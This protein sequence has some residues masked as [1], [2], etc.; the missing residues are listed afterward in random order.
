MRWARADLWEHECGETNV[1]V[2]ICGITNEDDA[3]FAA[4]MGADAVG[5]MFAPSKRQIAPTK[6]ADIAK[7]LPPEVLTVGVFRDELPDRVVDITLGAGLRAAQLSGH[8]SPAVTKTVRAKVPFVIQAFTPG[9]EAW[10]HAADHGADVVMLDN[11]QPGSGKVFDWTLVDGRAGRSM[12]LVVAGGLSPENVGDAIRHFR[13]WGVDVSS[14]VER[15]PGRKDAIKMKD[16]IDA[17]REAAADVEDELDASAD[18]DSPGHDGRF[19]DVEEH[20]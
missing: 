9:T 10:S 19:F 6:A 1:W 3:L 4:A 13:P 15:E 7:R 5:F 11:A 8:E 16:F 20:T 12:K 14:A 18:H 17:A 2:K